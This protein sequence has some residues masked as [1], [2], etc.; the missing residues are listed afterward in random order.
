MKV[1]LTLP[2]A[3][4][5][6]DGASWAE[7]ATLARLV[8]EGGGDSLWVCDHFLDRHPGREVG[9][10]EPFTLL[11]ALAASTTR[12]T[13]GPLVAATAFRSPGLLAK[14]ASTLDSIAGGRL[15]LGLGSGWHEPEFRAFGYPY[16]HL[17]G[18]FEESLVATRALLDG[19]RVTTAGSW[20]TLD[21]AVVLPTPERRIPIV[22]AGRG[23]RMLRLAARHADGWQAA[24]FGWPD[25]DFRA[26]RDRMVSACRAERR[27][28][29]LQVF[30]GVEVT[31]P[32][33]SGD[34]HLPFDA[35]AVADGL[36]AWQD[37]GVDHVQLGVHPGTVRTF[38]TAL[39]G[40]RRFR[41]FAALPA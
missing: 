17:V 15:I 37:E 27:S 10:H 5:D 26:Q 31:N 4:E 11:A 22:V 8:E 18:R 13:I 24:W 12:V 6:G 25:D 1:G 30:V 34:P 35:P 36:A 21:D 9:Y 7:I 3:P 2:Q 20:T 39:D 23:P 29:S 33:G 14:M 32:D 16:D 19:E 28:A 40:I 41:R 38:T